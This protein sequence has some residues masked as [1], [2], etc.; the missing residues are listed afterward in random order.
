MTTITT[1]SKPV[2]CLKS[3]TPVGFRFGNYN[4]DMCMLCRGPL[5]EVC[6]VCQEKGHNVCH[7]ITEDDVDY[8]THCYA[9]LQENM[10]NSKSKNN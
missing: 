3:F 5:T 6:Y 9:L 1:T 8:H 7:V 4:I 2:F 10:K